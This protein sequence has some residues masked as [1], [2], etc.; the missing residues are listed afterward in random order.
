MPTYTFK[1][2]LYFYFVERFLLKAFLPFVLA[3]IISYA[4]QNPDWLW[5]A[6]VF[7]A[8]EKYLRDKGFWYTLKEKVGLS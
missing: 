4:A 1:E 8:L 5:L 3:A 2:Q 6:P 7:I